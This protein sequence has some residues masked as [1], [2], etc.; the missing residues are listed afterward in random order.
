M[1]DRNGNVVNNYSYDEW[2]NITTSN[3]TVSNPFKYAG[4]IYDQETGLYYL[5]A[6]YYDS[7]I[8]RFINEDTVEG[9]VDNPLSLNLYFY[10]YN[11]PLIYIDD[12]GNTPIIMK[13]GDTYYWEHTDRLVDIVLSALS[14]LPFG[15]ITS[16]AIKWLAYTLYDCEEVSKKDVQSDME[17]ALDIVSD[18]ISN[19]KDFAKD[20]TILTKVYSLLSSA[21]DLYNQITDT[22]WET[23]YI[24][25]SLLGRYLYS[26]DRAVVLAKGLYANAAIQKLIDEGE[27]EY[28][29]NWDGTI[30]WVSWHGEVLNEIINEINSMDK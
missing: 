21:K 27:I 20:I 15:S 3:E 24:T 23:E 4:A 19:T 25:D 2:E 14:F 16:K 18:L 5:N 8:G 22:T 28:E 9:Q 12:T 6:R 26:T 10:C 7:S 11:N 1:V 29:F 30:K 13:V 17:D